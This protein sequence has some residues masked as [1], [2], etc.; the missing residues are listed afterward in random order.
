MTRPPF[1]LL[2]LGP[3][4][5]TGPDG[6]VTGRPAQQRRLALLAFLGCAP[7]LTV[8][9]DRLLALLWPE[10]DEETARHLLADSVY[11]L[12][13]ALG[14][15]AIVT[16]GTDLR[17]APEL[18][19]VDVPTFRR[20]AGAGRWA[21]ALALYRGDFLDG[22]LVR[23]AGEFDRWAELERE[24]LRHDAAGAAEALA[25]GLDD[26]RRTADAVPW[27]ERALELAPYD[28]AAFRRLLDLLVRLDN[29]SRAEADARAFVERLQTDLGVS[30]SAETLRAIR[31][32]RAVPAGEPIVVVAASAASGAAGGGGRAGDL[33]TRN[34]TL[35]GRYL[36]HRRTRS[37]VERAIAY[38]TRATERDPRSAESWAGLADAWC[39]LGGRGYLPVDEAV[40]HAAPCVERALALDPSLSAAHASVGGLAMMLRD[41]PRGDA[42][43]RQAIVLDPGNAD[44][45]HWLA[46]TLLTGY[47]RRDEALREQSIAVQL[48]PLSPVPVGT[49]GWHRYL[50]GEYAL[51]RAEFERAVD[52]DTDFEEGHAGLA[53]AAARLG[54]VPGAEAALADGLARRHDLRGDLLAEGAAAL[55]VLGQRDRARERAE[56]AARHGATPLML[57][58]A[59]GAIGDVERAFDRLAKASFEVYWAPHAVW[60]D[61][62]LDGLRGDRRFDDVLA[63]VKAAWRPAWG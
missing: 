31:E 8:S 11:L 38:F 24:R 50:R 17:L 62:R 13:R 43:L 1:Q 36:W 35:H 23:K 39:V 41:W 55:A 3:V 21:E 59:W 42:A 5:L 9:R 22:F 37:A 28:E 40:A 6:P 51:S 33:A 25:A 14:G 15:G 18:V 47:G 44:A 32:A 2:L 10:S 46:N 53:R 52:L 12:R 20:A 58:L 45:Y 16:A 27:A 19:G 29:R 48:N 54:D 30:P 57:A 60:W 56:E 63:R 34:L 61:P 4:S 49:L 7:D 26:E